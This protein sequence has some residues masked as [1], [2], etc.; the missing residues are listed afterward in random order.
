M[1]ELPVLLD[2]SP[3]SQTLSWGPSAVGGNVRVLVATDLVS[4]G[5]DLP[6]V[7]LVINFDIPEKVRSPGKGCADG[8]GHEEEDRTHT[9]PKEV[10]P[11]GEIFTGPCPTVHV[12][13]I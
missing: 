4:R 3:L 1:A 9:S 6:A 2:P 13:C 7:D 10:V 11:P 12:M 8:G 5:L